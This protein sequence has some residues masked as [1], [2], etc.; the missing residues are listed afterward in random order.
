MA[1]R[2]RAAPLLNRS[3][4][5]TTVGCFLF[6]SPHVPLVILLESTRT[7]LAVLL[8]LFDFFS[9]AHEETAGESDCCLLYV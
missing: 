1:G 4:A 3:T 7:V 9:G 6:F 2:K 8:F 5:E